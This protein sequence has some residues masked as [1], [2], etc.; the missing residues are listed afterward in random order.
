MQDNKYVSNDVFFSFFQ[1]KSV[2][3]V[4][5]PKTQRIWTEHDVSV[6]V[7]SSKG[8]RKMIKIVF[9]G[10][11]INVFPRHHQNWDMWK[12]KSKIILNMLCHFFF[13]K[14]TG[15]EQLTLS[16]FD[17]DTQ[18]KKI[19]SGKYFFRRSGRFPRFSRPTVR[20]SP[21]LINDRCH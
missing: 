20:V 10:Q 18:I 19:F 13:Q 1:I 7:S 3:P 15:F 11:I 4:R 6:R 9:R 16:A 17:C 12:K 5:L 8:E 2:I 21:L 14:L